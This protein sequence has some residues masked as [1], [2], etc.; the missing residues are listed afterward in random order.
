MKPK[1]PR[2]EGS[3]RREQVFKSV[4]YLKKIKYQNK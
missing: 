4:K 2:E 1:K 3:F